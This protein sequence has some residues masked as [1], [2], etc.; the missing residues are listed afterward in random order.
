M[1]DAELRS[2]LGRERLHQ[3][4]YELCRTY[5]RRPGVKRPAGRRVVEASLS[6][7]GVTEA[8]WMGAER[9]FRLTEGEAELRFVVRGDGSV[10]FSFL[11]LVAGDEYLGGTVQGLALELARLAGE[12]DPQPRYP[13]PYALDDDALHQVLGFGVG[14]LG[15]IARAARR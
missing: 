4:Y 11:G 6:G 12:P 1:D 14:L 13:L 3:R 10:E 5:P 7:L 2:L 9:V 15:A 8:Q